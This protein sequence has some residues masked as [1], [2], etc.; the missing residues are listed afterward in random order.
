V[1]VRGLTANLPTAGTRTDAPTAGSWLR[2]DAA[3]TASPALPLPGIFHPRLPE[4]VTA[5]SSDRDT[6]CVAA[7]DPSLDVFG[8]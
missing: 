4:P 6:A 2:T 3:I 7:G 8:G 1:E 5:A